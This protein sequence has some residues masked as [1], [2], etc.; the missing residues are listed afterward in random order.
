M[1]MGS[2][3]KV[4]LSTPRFITNVSRYILSGS[5][6]TSCGDDINSRQG[7]AYNNNI[8]PTLTFTPTC[9]IYCEPT[10]NPQPS[11]NPSP[12]PPTPTPTSPQDAT[13]IDAIIDVQPV[14]ASWEPLCFAYGF[15]GEN[16]P[17]CRRRDSTTNEI[18]EGGILG[19]D[20]YMAPCC[21]DPDAP[22]NANLPADACTAGNWAP[23]YP[24]SV[25]SS[26][27]GT[28]VRLERIIRETCQA[29]IVDQNNMITAL[30]GGQPSCDDLGGPCCYIVA[31][32]GSTVVPPTCLNPNQVTWVNESE[33]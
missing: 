14:D 12:N 13:V 27:V 21:K 33:L 31:P 23:G 29:Y 5:I 25:P 2:Y 9:D 3:H 26:H 6:V 24:K 16:G 28:C 1:D 18:N 4:V 32:Q 15:L 7:L 22:Y 17:V 30:D 8:A 20:M 10:S 11:P 19:C